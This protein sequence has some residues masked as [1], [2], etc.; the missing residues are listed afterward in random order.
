VTK[1]VIGW[2][3]VTGSDGSTALISRRMALTRF[4]GSPDVRTST[5]IDCHATCWYDRYIIGPGS[6]SSAWSRM[7]PTMPTTVHG[8][9]ARGG[10]I[11]LP[12]G[13]SLGQ[14]RFAI[15][16]V[17]TMTPGDSLA[18]LSSIARPRLSGMPAAAK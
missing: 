7:S 11:C 14:T 15:D 9:S 13:S 6:C 2:I 18:S 12:I 1:R 3:S 10:R 8:L 5:H 17:M 4:N 16:S